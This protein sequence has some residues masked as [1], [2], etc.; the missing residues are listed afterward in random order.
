MW[1]WHWWVFFS[2][3]IPFF[4]ILAFTWPAAV[5]AFEVKYGSDEPKQP[6]ALIVATLLKAVVYAAVV[7]AVVGFLF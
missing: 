1:N 2:A 4:A 3:I 5:L 6:S 7:T